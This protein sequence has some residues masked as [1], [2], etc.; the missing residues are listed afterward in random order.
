MVEWKCGYCEYDIDPE[1]AP[2]QVK[3]TTL[4]WRASLTDQGE[5]ASSYGTVSTADQNRVYTLPALQAV[6]E[7]VMVGWVQDAME[8]PT[9][10]EVE[11]SLQAQIDLLVTPTT[12][13]LTPGA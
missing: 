11:A 13:G 3:V 6:P 7:S 8:D 5:T 1:G 2:G 10:E 4:H 9:Y 12:G